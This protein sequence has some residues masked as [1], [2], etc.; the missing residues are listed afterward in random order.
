MAEAGS[1]VFPG[2]CVLQP[3]EIQQSSDKIRLGNGLLPHDGAV[4][5]TKAGVLAKHANTSKWWVRGYQKRYVAVEDDQVLGVIVE[6]GGE[7][8]KVDIGAGSHAVLGTLAFDGATKRNRPNLKV[9]ELL[10]A[11]VLRANKDIEVE[12]TCESVVG[13]KDWVTGESTY[14]PLTGGNVCKV[15]LSL[16]QRLLDNDAPVLEALGNVVP[17]ELAIGVNGRVWV[18]AETPRNMI[19]VAN[20]I[21]N[22]EFMTGPE[23][24]KMVRDMLNSLDTK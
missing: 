16:A 1:F 15:S 5:A 22:S 6:K 17:F 20:A 10:Y 11:R 19:V 9:G 7:T 21:A 23:A 13:K 14:G 4:V 18:N 3:E 8:L 24:Q 2:D 12:L